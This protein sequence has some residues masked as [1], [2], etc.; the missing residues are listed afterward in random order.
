MAIITRSLGSLVDD[1]TGLTAVLEV[2]YDNVALLL[3]AIRCINP[4][5][6]AVQLTATQTSNDR[7]YT[8]TFPAGQTT[9]LTIPT[10]QAA[11]LSITITANGR[12][13][14]VEYHIQWAP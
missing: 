6:V 8:Q 5:P 12:L 10:G 3:T 11:R 9:T 7:E 14:G 2:Q 13:D 1:V 4:T